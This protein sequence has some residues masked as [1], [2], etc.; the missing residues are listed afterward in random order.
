M[1]DFKAYTMTGEGQSHG[2]KKSFNISKKIGGVNSTKPP[3]FVALQI[4]SIDNKI[5]RPFLFKLSRL[6][7]CSM[8]MSYG[9]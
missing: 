3:S 9:T 6:T 7:F 1:G 4:T 8:Y 2:I 5:N